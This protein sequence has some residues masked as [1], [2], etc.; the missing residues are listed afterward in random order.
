MQFNLS[1]IPHLEPLIFALLFIGAVGLL[2][3][4]VLRLSEAISHLSSKR[5]AKAKPPALLE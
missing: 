4:A 1:W 3:L 2:I 5:K